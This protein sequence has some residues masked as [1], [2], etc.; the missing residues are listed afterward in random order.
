MKGLDN[1]KQVECYEKINL[2]I[3]LIFDV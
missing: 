3:N 1:G 2:N